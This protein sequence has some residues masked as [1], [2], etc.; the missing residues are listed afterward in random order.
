MCNKNARNQHMQKLQILKMYLSIIL[1]YL[2]P[3]TGCPPTI[4][5]QHN[6]NFMKTEKFETNFLL[7]SQLLFSS[8]VF[9]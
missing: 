4:L 9:T 3:K 7:K 8:L 1:K 5:V 2:Q 6:H